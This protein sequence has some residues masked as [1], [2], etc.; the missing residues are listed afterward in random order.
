MNKTKRIMSI[1]YIKNSESYDK[2]INKKI[3]LDFSYKNTYSKNPNNFYIHGK[4]KGYNNPNNLFFIINSFNIEINNVNNVNK[5]KNIV[6][7]SKKHPDIC[8]KTE[9]ENIY[10]I[11]LSNGENKGVPFT[12]VKN[13]SK[14]NLDNNKFI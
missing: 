7:F 2:I 3:I 13:F 14:L 1:N 8:W 10:N 9:E 5:D 12:F 6:K 4:I 11:V